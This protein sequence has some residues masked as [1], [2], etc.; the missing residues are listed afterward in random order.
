V[1]DAG[2]ADQGIEIVPR[3][4]D[5]T[6]AA[7][8]RLLA[9][10]ERVDGAAALNEQALLAIEAGDQ[11]GARHLLGTAGTDAG[12]RGLLEAYAHLDL[13]G[14]ASGVEAECVVHPDHRRHGWGARLVRCTVEES[15]PHPVLMWSHG[16]HP[17]ARRLAQRLGFDRVRDLWQMRRDLTAALPDVELPAG[18]RLRTFV[19]GRD[20]PAWLAVNARAFASHPEQGGL[21]AVDLARR[22]GADW[23]DPGGFFLAERGNRLVGFHW[24]KVHAG[25]GTRPPVGEVYVVGVD[26]D[27]QGGGLGRALTLAGLHH[28]RELGLPEVLL[29]VEADNLAARRLYERLG[30]DHVATDA[31]YRS[32]PGG[33]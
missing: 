12:G 9:D 2:T 31:Q 8:R 16:D 24:T 32:G 26:P 33:P 15:S 6:W 21:D 7:V 1:T 23:F 14:A 25:D 29:Y 19:T 4:D 27:A 17:G 20:E 22:T 28:L 13:S 18:V 11:P 5:R 10:A 30:F 3:L